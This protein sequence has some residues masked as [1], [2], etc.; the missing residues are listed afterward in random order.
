M[1]PRL[2]PAEARRLASAAAR[3]LMD[4]MK[5]TTD[6]LARIALARAV[7]ALVPW[8]EP[9]EARR[10]ASAAAKQVVEATGNITDPEALH[11]LAVAVAALA[12]QL[13]AGES[14]QRTSAVAREVENALAKATSGRPVVDALGNTIPP[15]VLFPHLAGAL[16]ALAPRL[17]TAEASAAAR[18]TVDAMARVNDS[19]NLY[20]L[21]NA[22]TALI[23][24]SGPGEASERLCSEA[25]AVGY[26]G[27][28]PTR[29][30]GL[31]LL[32]EASRPLPG[33][34]TEQ[35]LV[36]L[37]KTPTFRREARQVIVRQLGWQCGQTFAN[38]WEFVDWAREHRPDLDLTSPPVRLTN[39]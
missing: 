33:R 15:Y 7:A 18:Q 6:P 23:V 29:L 27:A 1:T 30:A 9:T 36:D 20:E 28:L 38:Q 26:A 31:A 35:Q 3:Q 13:E 2:A 17:E 5:N 39:P 10:L 4:T 12:P 25:E 37:L 8:L 34:F 24:R 21:A 19:Y 32:T 14:A 11:N 16:A 22:L